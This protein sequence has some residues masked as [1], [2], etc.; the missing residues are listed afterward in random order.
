M[1]R[2]PKQGTE[3]KNKNK[4]KNKDDKKQREIKSRRKY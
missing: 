4:N 3:N 2:K 1:G